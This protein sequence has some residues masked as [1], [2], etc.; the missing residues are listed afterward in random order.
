MKILL[1]LILLLISVGLVYFFYLGYKS[2]TGTANGIVDSKLTACSNKPNCICTEY[3]A[4]KSHYTDAIE[5]PSINIENLVNAITTSG[6]TIIKNQDNYI[7]ATY[8]S[9]FFKYVDDFEI[10]I[11][12]ENQLIHIRSAS[13]VGHSDMGANLKRI[14]SFKETLNTPD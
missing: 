8:T 4:D 10:R 7:S 12:P 14:Q 2:Q 13:R 9:G 11:D 5:H 3:P 1:I 6:G